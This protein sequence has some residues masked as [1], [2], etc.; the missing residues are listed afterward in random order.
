MNA[1]KGGAVL[2]A[3]ARERK[4]KGRHLLVLIRATTGEREKGSETFYFPKYFVV[5]PNVVVARDRQSD[6]G[7]SVNEWSQRK[8]DSHRPHDY[9]NRS[10]N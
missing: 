8:T 6:T 3:T 7:D 5:G 1:C 4:R 9:F 10:Q 2:P